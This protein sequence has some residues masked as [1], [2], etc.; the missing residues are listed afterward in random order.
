MLQY[1]TS[2][3][4]RFGDHPMPPHTRLNWEFYAV[5]RGKCA[6]SMPSQEHSAMNQR[7][8]WVFPPDCTHGWRGLKSKECRVVCFHF[9][10]VPSPLREIALKKNYK[11][12]QL[13]EEQCKRLKILMNELIP[14]FETP[15]NFSNLVFE[16]ALLELTFM[17]LGDV[18]E[19]P[20]AELAQSNMHKVNAAIAWYLD[21][22]SKPP[23]LEE[24]AAHVHSSVSNL[25]RIF[26]L[27]LNES[28]Q[29]V[30]TR[31]RLRAAMVLMSESNMKIERVAEQCGYSS[32]SDFSRAFS[33]EF[34]ISPSAWR[35][36]DYKKIPGTIMSRPWLG[37]E[38]WTPKKPFIS[39]I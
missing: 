29:S 6:P 2:G 27:I 35:A 8:L 22:L 16:R 10:S 18:Q 3:G 38:S 13:T 30:F 33:K 34:K 31:L 23:R 32:A 36:N 7:T 4:R 20:I 19:I 14:H 28:P 26:I 24:V 25:R 9:A 5:V 21:H 1:I 17:A 12:Y 15:T 11:E 37:S 39:T